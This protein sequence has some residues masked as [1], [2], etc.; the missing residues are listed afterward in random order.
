MELNLGDIAVSEAAGAQMPA[1]VRQVLQ[2]GFIGHSELWTLWKM[3]GCEGNCGNHGVDMHTIPS[4]ARESLRMVD[5][6]R[7]RDVRSAPEK[8]VYS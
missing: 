8:S 7:T 4:N 1:G 2:C 5:F 6:T 3:D